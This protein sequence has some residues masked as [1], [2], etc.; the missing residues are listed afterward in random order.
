[1]S[2]DAYQLSVEQVIGHNQDRR[3]FERVVR[4]PVE[5]WEA[6]GRVLHWQAAQDRYYCRWRP[7]WFPATPGLQDWWLVFVLDGYGMV[8]GRD[9]F[10]R[11]VEE[12]V[13]KQADW[14]RTMAAVV[15]AS[16]FPC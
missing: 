1:M 14:P 6:E 15:T 4:T 3:W 5:F 7:T 2:A 16:T 11:Y 9:G 10:S 8:R 12:T 13:S